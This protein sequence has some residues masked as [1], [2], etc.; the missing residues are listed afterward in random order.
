[1]LGLCVMMGGGFFT[2][3]MNRRGCLGI[4]STIIRESLE[5]VEIVYPP[6]LIED[7][8]NAQILHLECS[9]NFSAILSNGLLFTFGSNEHGKL[10]VGKKRGDCL[11]P[12]LVQFSIS[13]TNEDEVVFVTQVSLGSSYASAIDAI[14]RLFSWGYGGGGNLGLGSRKSKSRPCLVLGAIECER[15]ISVH[16]TAGQ[17]TVQTPIAKPG[18]EAP[19]TLAISEN[20]IVYSWGSC[21]KG[22]LGNLSKKTLGKEDADELVPYQIGGILRDGDG[23]ESSHYF[24]NE[25]MKQVASSAMHSSFLTADGE[26]YFCGCG[27]TGRGGIKKFDEGLGG[28]RSRM[29]CYI[30]E[31]IKVEFFSDNRIFVE[32]VDTARRHMIA[33]TSSRELIP[34]STPH[35]SSEN[36]NIISEEERESE[37]KEGDDE[38]N[39]QNESLSPNALFSFEEEDNEIEDHYLKHRP[40][41]WDLEGSDFIEAQ[42]KEK[43][44]GRIK[45]EGEKEI[46]RIL[47]KHSISPQKT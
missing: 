37:E 8:S 44:F 7:E 16:C 15:M 39:P 11:V 17:I 26:L 20:G 3:G 14:G 5:P 2:F 31:P 29:K 35:R 13:S 30:I 32:Q 28:R 34:S 42:E 23:R 10:G 19:H 6:E 27:S 21:Y 47:E 45:D 4:N 41:G 12:T 40:M 24:E 25:I 18:S 22:Q 33:L 38:E 9:F 1:M 46:I 36:V 43:K